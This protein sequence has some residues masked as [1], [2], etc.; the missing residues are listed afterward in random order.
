MYSYAESS[1]F[2]HISVACAQKYSSHFG[3][4]L[5]VWVA[6]SLSMHEYDPPLVSLSKRFVC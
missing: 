1:I 2:V 4:Q 3:M 5:N 6:P